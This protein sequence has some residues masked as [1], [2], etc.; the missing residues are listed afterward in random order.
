MLFPHFKLLCVMFVYFTMDGL[1]F[2]SN[3]SKHLLFH[4]FSYVWH[5]HGFVDALAAYVI[6]IHWILW[7]LN[8]ILA[9]KC[10][11]NWIFVWG[12]RSVC[13]IVTLGSRLWGSHNS[14][15]EHSSLLGSWQ[16]NIY[17]LLLDT[18][19]IV[20]ALDV[21]WSALYLFEFLSWTDTAFAAEGPYPYLPCSQHQ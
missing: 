6:K 16:I 14:I 9:V 20:E 4:C 3:S 10:H 5:C 18:S 19:N 1:D 11:F 13:C 12:D 7:F 17:Y 21:H 8:F 15:Y 2:L